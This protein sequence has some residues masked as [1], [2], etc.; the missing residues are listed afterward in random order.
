MAKL[1]KANV[2]L[3]LN[4][5]AINV[6]ETVELS[7]SDADRMSAVL[8]PVNTKKVAKI[9]ANAAVKKDTEAVEAKA[10]TDAKTVITNNGLSLD[11]VIAAIEELEVSETNYT[12]D[13]KPDAVVLSD[14]LDAFVSAKLR[15]EAWA[16]Y[17]KNQLESS[18]V[19]SDG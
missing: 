12:N 10:K 3:M 9:K 19:D 13:G 18:Q 6:G 11:D 2:N 1:Y 4:G 15:D 17:R 14:K 8:E 16:S 5:K 7:S